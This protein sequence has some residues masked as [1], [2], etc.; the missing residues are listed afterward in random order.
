[1]RES[2]TKERY[3]RL[4]NRIV[5]LEKKLMTLEALVIGKEVINI[6]NTPAF[7]I[8][9]IVC[10]HYGIPPAF[11]KR[12]KVGGTTQTAR[13]VGM[14][15]NRY[16]T[17]DTLSDTGRLYGSVCHG[18][19]LWAVNKVDAWISSDPLFKKEVKMLEEKT[20]NMLEEA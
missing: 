13:F 4:V 15:L 11:L 19:A 9:K 1:M 16:F 12:K 2:L 14:H 8:Q 17:S 20:R 10:D 7:K 18:A 5:T 3:K 6:G